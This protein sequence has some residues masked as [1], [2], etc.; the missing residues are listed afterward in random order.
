[1]GSKQ[2]GHNTCAKVRRVTR[3]RWPRS[4]LCPDQLL[5]KAAVR[6]NVVEFSKTNSQ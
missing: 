6:A 2:A 3:S 5:V 4:G 1:M